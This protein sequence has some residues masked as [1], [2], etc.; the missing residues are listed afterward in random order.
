MNPMWEDYYRL[1]NW[2]RLTLLALAIGLYILVEFTTPLSSRLSGLSFPLQLTVIFTAIGLCTI[3]ISI[4]VLKWAEWPCP[5]C[6]WKFVQ[7]KLHWGNPLLVFVLVL[8]RLVFDSSCAGCR[9]KCGDSTN[10]F[11]SR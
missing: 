3:L 8:R 9:L 6:G 1:R 4:P 7:P 5:R 11:D 10:E 2:A